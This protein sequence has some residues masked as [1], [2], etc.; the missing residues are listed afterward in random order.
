[1]TWNEYNRA[2]NVYGLGDDRRRHLHDRDRR[3]DARRRLGLAHGQVRHGH[4]QPRVGRGRPRRR[5]GRHRERGR[6][7]GPVLGDQRR[8]RQLRRR[9]VV[10]VPR[11]SGRHDLRRDRRAS[12]R[13]GRR[14]LRLLPPV[15]EEPSRR[16][17]RVRRPRPCARRKRYEDRRVAGLPL[18]RSA[19]GRGGR[20]TAARV[21][22]APARSDRPDAL[23]RH[24]HAARPRV[25]EGR[26]QLLEVR[27]LHGALR[28]SR[29]HDGGRVRGGAVDDE[30]HGRRALPRRR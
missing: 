29:P 15:H 27:V 6:R 30:R 20:E 26:A 22:A 13:F 12:A 25:P 17:H 14:G 24:Q 10:R 9:H 18:R 23:S 2:A 3:A 11:A 21:R 1:M 4:R 16:A 19:A 28:R 7:R 5:S 8:R